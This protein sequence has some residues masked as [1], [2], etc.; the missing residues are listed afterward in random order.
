MS[1]ASE[2]ALTEHDPHAVDRRAAR[3]RRRRR[4]R[5][6]AHR[7]EHRRGVVVLVVMV[8]PVFW[9]ISTA[10]KPT[11]EINSLKP[12]WVP[13]H[14]TLQH[15]RDAIDRPV[16]LGRTSKNSLII[17]GVSVADRRSC[18][19][20]SRRSRSRST[21]SAAASSSSCS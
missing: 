14:P 18:S 11:D 13:W 4:R 6:G 19:R 16:L 20:S 17:V 1:A 7:L 5:D 8:F 10:F 2:I 12:T 21:A 15:F 9:M 3:T